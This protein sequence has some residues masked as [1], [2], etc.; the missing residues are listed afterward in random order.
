MPIARAL[1]EQKEEARLVPGTVRTDETVYNV[2]RLGKN[3]I[4][5]W[6]H[7]EVIGI[8]PD[9]RRVVEFY[10]WEKNISLV[11]TYVDKDVPIYN[12]LEELARRGEDLRQYESVW[13]YY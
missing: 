12:Y 6:Q 10:P 5:A 2:P 3:Y 11:E 9:G 13:Y 8:T 7:H 4:R 1:Q